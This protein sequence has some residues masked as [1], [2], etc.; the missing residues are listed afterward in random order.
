MTGDHSSSLAHHTSG[1]YRIRKSLTKNVVP[2]IRF[3]YGLRIEAEEESGTLKDRRQVQDLNCVVLDKSSRWKPHK[4]RVGTKIRIT[5]RRE[6][7]CIK[8]C[9]SMKF[10][11]WKRAEVMGNGCRYE[12]KRWIGRMNVERSV[13]LFDQGE[14]L[15]G[16][17][18]PIVSRGLRGEYSSTKTCI[19]VGGRQGWRPR[20]SLVSG[21]SRE[22]GRGWG[23]VDVVLTLEMRWAREEELRHW[24][25]VFRWY[26]Y[27]Y[28]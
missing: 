18:V 21:W 9:E 20:A 7:M 10:R 24:A 6:R 8:I 27:Y 22:R 16:S 23:R 14:F 28:H 5:E 26:Y 17:A 12:G 2:G 19:G 1:R 25:D 4:S 3:S 11:S 15:A 13:D